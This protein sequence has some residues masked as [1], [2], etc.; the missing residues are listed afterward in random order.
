[1]K[2]VV[3]FTCFAFAAM[4]NEKTCEANGNSCV[5]SDERVTLL[6]VNMQLH[7]QTDQ[8]SEEEEEEEEEEETDSKEEQGQ[9]E[10]EIGLSGEEATDSEEDM[11]MG[12]QSGEEET[13]S[14]EDMSMGGQSGKEE[15]EEETDSEEDMSMGKPIKLKGFVSRANAAVKGKSLWIGS[16][17]SSRKYYKSLT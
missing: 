14:E 1:M 3:L 16:L 7:K 2:Y 11:N 9:S 12:G 8:Q 17:R 13:D 5:D 6:Q 10:K 4:A 15:E